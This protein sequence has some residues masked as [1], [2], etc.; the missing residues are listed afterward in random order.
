MKKYGCNSFRVSLLFLVLLKTSIVIGIDTS[1]DSGLLPLGYQSFTVRDLVRVPRRFPTQSLSVRNGIGLSP[2]M[3]H[4][5][6][7]FSFYLLC[8]NY[9]RQSIRYAPP[10]R[11][12]V[13]AADRRLFAGFLVPFAR[14]QGTGHRNSVCEVSA[15]ALR[16]S[17]FT[18][19]LHDIYPCL[20]SWP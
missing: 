14:P 9:F 18:T 6:V 1:L 7:R 15:L 2:Q 3:V 12:L 11:Q 10:Y 17:F 5:W 8:L 16:D 20:L 19:I 13:W 4:K